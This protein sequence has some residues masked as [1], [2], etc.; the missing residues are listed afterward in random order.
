MLGHEGASPVSFRC[1]RLILSESDSTE[2]TKDLGHDGDLPSRSRFV[3]CALQ[4]AIE[5]SQ[6]GRASKR[7]RHEMERIA[8]VA[9]TRMAKSLLVLMVV[10]TAIGARL[11]YAQRAE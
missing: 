10:R 9:F 8:T 4:D 6:I 7:R 1:Y 5:R 3:T 2:R 11:G